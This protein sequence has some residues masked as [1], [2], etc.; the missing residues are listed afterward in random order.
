MCGRRGYREGPEGPHRAFAP[1][2][3]RSSPP[4]GADRAGMRIRRVRLLQAMGGAR[5]DGAG[6]PCRLV[7]DP[8]TRGRPGSRSCWLPRRACRTLARRRERGARDS[9]RRVFRHCNRRRFQAR[10]AE[11]RPGH[12]FDL[13]ERGEPALPRGD[14]VHVR[15]WRYYDSEIL[16]RMRPPHQDNTRD[17][18]ASHPQG[19]RKIGHY[20]GIS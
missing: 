1:G 13:D 10:I 17:L 6:P 15:G 3:I 20:L 18:V 9:L 12:H 14:F 16:T 11:T 19:G 2:S 7:L 5:M 4:Q 8:P